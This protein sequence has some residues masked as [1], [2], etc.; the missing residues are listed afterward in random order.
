MT[1]KLLRLTLIILCV[2]NSPLS[3]AGSVEK[4]TENFCKLEF[5]DLKEK[6]TQIFKSDKMKATSKDLEKYISKEDVALVKSDASSTLRKKS[7][8][9]EYET[10]MSKSENHLLENMFKHRNSHN[11]NGTK[12]IR[13]YRKEQNAFIS[14]YGDSSNPSLEIQYSTYMGLRVSSEFTAEQFKKMTKDDSKLNKSI[15]KTV[16]KIALVQ[17][18]QEDGTITYSIQVKEKSIVATSDL[19]GYIL[20]LQNKE[21]SAFY[22]KDNEKF[23]N[24]SGRSAKETEPQVEKYM[25]KASGSNISK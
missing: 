25:Q 12:F 10:F 1:H 22:K 9:K 11:V 2:C 23:I 13:N 20:R 18:T 6:I 16:Q 19:D 8:H 15:D 4:L 24:T 14:Y 3:F 17:E 21:C 7:T 5:N